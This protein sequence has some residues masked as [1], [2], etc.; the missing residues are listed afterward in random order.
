M[1]LDYIRTRDL[2]QY[3]V[4]CGGALPRLPPQVRMFFRETVF[5]KRPAFRS[6]A[7]AF[8]ALNRPCAPGWRRVSE[9]ASYC[10]DAAYDIKNISA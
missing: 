8:F 10:F 6:R 4:H 5:R 1:T 3:H 2:P 7:S 9:F